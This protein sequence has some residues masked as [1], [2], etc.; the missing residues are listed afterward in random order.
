MEEMREVKAWSVS[1]IRLVFDVVSNVLYRDFPWET[2]WE[3]SDCIMNPEGKDCEVTAVLFLIC[4]DLR[5]KAMMKL[6]DDNEE[7]GILLNK[8][9]RYVVQPGDLCFPGGGIKK[10]LDNVLARFFMV[11]RGSVFSKYPL[12]IRKAISLLAVTALREA[13]E[14]VRLNPFGVKICGVLPPCRL[15][16]FRKVIVPIVGVVEDSSIGVKGNSCEVEKVLWVPFSELLDPSQYARYRLYNYPSHLNFQDFLC[17][18]HQDG[19]ATEIIWGATFRMVMDFMGKFFDFMPPPAE[20]L[21]VVPGI[22]SDAY[23]GRGR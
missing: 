8:R 16:M 14:E 22:L 15:V 6:R 5:E 18:I 10:P 9:S 21:P 3:I 1:N 11:F 12:K 19:V 23:L 13:W 17:F 4:P 20:D 7:L 2:F